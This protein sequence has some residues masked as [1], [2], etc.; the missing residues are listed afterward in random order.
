MDINGPF[1]LRKIKDAQADF[2]LVRPKWSAT[3]CGDK[4]AIEIIANLDWDTVH[5]LAMQV[6]QSLHGNDLS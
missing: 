2:I 5:W 6:Q 3:L 1:H 4:L